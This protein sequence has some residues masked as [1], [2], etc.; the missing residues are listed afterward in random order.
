M[1]TR[2]KVSVMS[3]SLRKLALVIGIGDYES[4]EILNNT[5]KDAH[6]MSVKLD[7]M[8]FISDGPKLDLTFERD[9]N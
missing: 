6:D 9:G 8:G 7:R 4:G 3:Q 1:A 5:Q 2:S